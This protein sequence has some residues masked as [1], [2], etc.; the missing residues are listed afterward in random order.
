MAVLVTRLLVILT[1]LCLQE[2]VLPGV[3]MSNGGQVFE[4]LYHLASLDQPRITN[5]ARSLLKLIPT[6]PVVVEL[7]DSISHKVTI[8]RTELNC[9]VMCISDSMQKLDR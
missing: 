1:L 9:S 8:V 5:R 2:K 3:I 6:N 7:L 4:M